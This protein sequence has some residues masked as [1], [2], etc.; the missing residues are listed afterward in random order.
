MYQLSSK[1]IDRGH[2]VIV[3][4]HAYAG[5]T[6]VRYLTN[7][8]KVYYVPFLI[9][10]R[11]TTFPTVFSFFPVFRN[12]VI[13]ERI[14]I[15]HGHASMSNLCNEAILHARTMGLRTVF[16]D[17]SLFG[18]ADAG[19]ILTNKLLKFTLSDVDHVICVSHTC[20]ENTVLRASLDPLMVSVIPNA[21]VAENFRP[22][23]RDQDNSVHRNTTSLPRPMG[24]DE[25]I[26]VVVIQRLY[27]NKGTDLLVGAIPHIL[28][29]HS[30]VRFIIAGNGPKAID[31]EQMIE[32]H[33]LQDRVL[34][35]GPVRHEEVRDVM[36]RGHIYLCPSLTEAFGTVIVEAASCGLYVVATRVGGIPEVLPTHMVEFAAPEE[37]D[38]AEATGRAIDK[39]RA[40]KVRTELFHSQV[41]QMYSWTDVAQRTE[42]VYD[43][44]SG[45][46]SH[47]EFYQAGGAAG[48]WSAT[49]GRAGMHSF[50][51]I[52]RLKRYYGC[53]VWAGKLFCLC[54]VIDYLLYVVLEIFAPRSR[55]DICKDWPK[56]ARHA[57]NGN[58][59][60]KG[61][62]TPI[63]TENP[64]RK[65]SA[66][67][68]RGRRQELDDS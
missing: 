48:V 5:R 6:G 34:M 28:A 43:G 9:I 50:A 24:P 66:R 45:V 21:V 53:G 7:G 62:S 44:I 33:M 56:K 20:K 52:E 29:A 19:S 14:E 65:R 4:T 55:I 37:E 63:I 11:E 42:R 46:I 12:I 64:G 2:K 31:L 54:V 1:L 51:L 61:L 26:T 8:I 30:N 40:G 18:F 15:V 3:I 36:V 49:Q 22:L 57:L 25:V 67:T 35:I 39:L 38:L 32:R 13:R 23:E 59:D 16:T 47:T 10:Y 68:R 60:T 17:H 41:K 27:Y 58:G